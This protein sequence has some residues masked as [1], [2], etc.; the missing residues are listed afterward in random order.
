MLKKK[1]FILLM[2][3]LGI[4]LLL[5]LNFML[6][7]REG[8]ERFL[9]PISKK[10]NQVEAQFDLDFIEILMRNRPD[11]A[12]TFSNLS[13]DSYHNY[14]LFD[15]AGKLI[16]WSD[17]SYIPDFE[18]IKTQEN[19]RI[20]EDREGIYFSKMRRFS[21]NEQ[22][23][24]LF[25]TYPLVNK[26][27][28]QNE[29]LPS[30]F[31]K[32]VFGNNRLEISPEPRNEFVDVKGS[33]NEY[34]FSINFG[35]GYQVIGQTNNIPLMVFFFSLLFLILISGFDFVK[36]IWKK[37]QKFIAVFYSCLILFSIRGFML[38]F[39][40]PQEYFDFSLFDSS[41]FASSL[42]NPSLGDLL[43]NMLC[44]IIPFSMIL[45]ILLG[46][47]FTQRFYEFSTKYKRWY[48][49]VLAYLTSSVLLVGFYYLYINIL[50]NAQW[51]LNILS[52]PSFDYFKGISLLLVF[53]GSAGY[54]LFSIIALSLVLEHRPSSKTYALKVLLVFS[55]PI[56]IG[57]SIFNW[58]YLLVYL[59]HL[60]FLI[61]IISF[62][63][64]KNIF[65]L[66]LNTF[67]TFFFGCLISAIVTGIAAHEVLLERQQQSKIRFGNQQLIENDVMAEFFL[68]DIMKR[69]SEDIFIKNA[70]TDPLQSKEPIERKIRRIHMT[71][72]FDQYAL[73]VKV[74]N[75]SGD[76]VLQRTDEENLQDLRVNYVKSDYVTSVRDLYFIK[77]TEEIGSN[78][79]Y[80]FIPL[81][82]DDVFL[83]TVYLEL[84]QIRILPGSVFP[85][86]LMD[87]NY[88]AS[89]ND[90]YYDFA[91]YLDGALQYG[92]GV[93]NYRAS[94]LHTFLD[95]S[96]LF[97]SGIY[98]K[99]YHHLGVKS[100]EKVVIVSSP[101]Y[102]IYYIL[103]DISLFFLFYILLTLM[104][105]VIYALLKGLRSFNFN[106]ATKL[107]MYLNFAFFFPILIISAIILG[108]LASS[109]QDE[110]HRQYFQKATLV[111]DNLSAIMEKQSAGVADREDF[112]EEVNNLAGTANI[113]IN[114]FD[115]SGFLMTSSQPNIFDK[116]VVTRYVNPMAIAEL[117]EGQNNLVLLE[118]SIGK[119][120]YKAVYSAI[121]SS[122]GQQV[123]AIIA[124][125]F[126]ESENE[127][128][129]L[130]ADV[131]SNIL[132]IFVLVFII[133]LFVSYF[134][135]K[136][137]TFPFKL[138]T[139]KLK[140][141]DLENNEP[142]YWPSKDEIGMLVNEYN[143]MLFKLEASKNV[144]ANTEK[145]S[146]WR[147]MAK[148]V[149]HEIKNPLTPMKL[150][151]QHLLRLQAAGKL[152]DPQMLKKPVE[153]LITQVDT[154]S[155]IATSFSTFAKMPL[156][157]NELMDFRNIVKSTIELFKN[158][159]RGTVTFED[160][161]DNIPLTVVGDDQLFGRVIS[162]LIIN[163]IQA[164]E[165]RKKPV[166]NVFMRE[167]GGKVIV[168]IKD[169]GKGIPEELQDKIFIPNFS[170][171]SEGSGL[172]LAI[173]K[174]GVETAGGKIW[175]ET[176]PGIGTSFFLS[177]DLVMHK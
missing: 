110:L 4:G 50:S 37:G 124:I 78:Q 12:L 101:I 47:S 32:S 92:V 116:R 56:V 36:T 44:L 157:K 31:N 112:F 59:T 69:I 162:N 18:N 29:Y 136:N 15:E 17:F 87:Q 24:I 20:L 158:R 7:N 154:L 163:G 82:R 49:F 107:Q 113:E 129:I 102:S 98:K 14:Y 168:E 148:Q 165:G 5:A 153:T 33:K 88:Q 131:L 63:L 125:P 46:P 121:R 43:L 117:I 45:A 89:L 118:E 86:L 55:T 142:M 41:R 122:D 140:V 8:E 72:Y 68:S 73:R 105:V 3:V 138:L 167:L 120:N 84:N 19:Q 9:K 30:G 96:A 26:R 174:S 80:A 159:E 66:G 35:Q 137:L 176:Q 2:A 119:L 79:Y 58:I 77:G 27:E 28:I 22:G 147:E 70:L 99:Q 150:T 40:F 81:Y 75:A 132:N 164:V 161:T 76:N 128:D 11:E 93:F 74:F 34:L 141:T 127:L 134:V 114:V 10:I 95:N 16:Y 115:K 166:V 25:Q 21:R 23:Y 64:H 57:L 91:V 71:N 38:F 13:I 173:A 109:Y 171:K 53:F 52:I 103:A 97:S 144:L 169:N 61:S 48:F 65:R 143:N 90:R 104:S 51:D 145:E 62:E 170:T 160:Y 106:Y 94:D 156:P 177:F 85:K 100:D 123:Q 139:Q 135:S 175:F 111:K 126:F 146:A 149:A 152:D 108:L 133:F 83:G 67:L 1:R 54:L 60:L 130:I 39:G 6:S 155:D 172:G 42:L 151:L